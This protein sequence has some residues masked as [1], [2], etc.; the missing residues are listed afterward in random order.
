MRLQLARLDG[1]RLLR[2]SRSSATRISATSATGELG[3][4][5]VNADVAKII[6]LPPSEMHDT[7]SAPGLRCCCRGPVH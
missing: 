7:W 2:V 1:R 3:L 5:G 4:E 6:A